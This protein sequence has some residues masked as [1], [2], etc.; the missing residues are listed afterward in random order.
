[1]D[2]IGESVE[3]RPAR[4]D[5][6]AT[7]LD[8]ERRSSVRFA[9]VPGLEHW[10]ED[11]T[12]MADLEP[13]LERGLVWVAVVGEEV[14]GWCYADVVDDS[15]FVE[16]IDVLPEFGRRGIGRQLLV[17]V[18]AEAT[19]RELAAVT[20]TTEAAIPWN[21]PL[22]EKPGFVVVPP[23]DRGPGLAA[24]VADEARRGLDITTRVSMRRPVTRSA[25]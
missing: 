15:L 21:R 6:L 23:A 18:S 14:V 9:D 16:Q 1:M 17:V 4:A 24:K 8:V 19:A 7:A 20:L 12:E 10:V 25:R 5:E 11:V 2:P 3:I 13:A 22:Y